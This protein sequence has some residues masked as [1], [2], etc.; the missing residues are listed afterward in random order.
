MYVDGHYIEN[1]PCRPFL[2]STIFDF[3]NYR[4]MCNLLQ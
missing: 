2:Y 4:H 1:G 3:H